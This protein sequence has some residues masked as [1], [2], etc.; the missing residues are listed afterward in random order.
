MSK[1]STK[2]S[3]SNN[4]FIP[5]LNLVPSIRLDRPS[6]PGLLSQ[7]KCLVFLLDFWLGKYSAIMLNTV[8]QHVNFITLC[9]ENYAK[10][11]SL[12]DRLDSL[13][14]TLEHLYY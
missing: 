4:K 9:I 2:H 11:R 3:Y 6:E 1:M 7:I 14:W 5:P 8:K 13:I 12:Q 10:I